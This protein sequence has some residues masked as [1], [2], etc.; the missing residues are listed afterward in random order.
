ME[1]TIQ[2]QEWVSMEYT[3]VGGLCTLFEEPQVLKKN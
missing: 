2:L 1:V 3:K